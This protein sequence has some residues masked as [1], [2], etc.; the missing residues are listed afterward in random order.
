MTYFTRRQAG[1]A[2]DPQKKWSDIMAE[3]KKHIRSGNTRDFRGAAGSGRS[4]DCG[5][6]LCF[7]PKSSGIVT[8]RINTRTEVYAER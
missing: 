5:V 6:L 2:G 7:T 1:K 4:P 8:M 3:T